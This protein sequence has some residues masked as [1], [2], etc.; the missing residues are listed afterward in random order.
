MARDY[1]KMVKTAKIKAQPASL[2]GFAKITPP[3][4]KPLKSRVY[5]KDMLREDPTDFS[6][7][8]FG[9]TALEQTPSIIGMGQSLK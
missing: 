7:S 8:G 4:L 5:T 1:S 2:R 3:R 6:N 9:D